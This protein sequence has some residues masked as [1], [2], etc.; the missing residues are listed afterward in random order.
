MSPG[1]QAGKETL[2]ACEYMLFLSRYNQSKF[3]FESHSRPNQSLHNL[4]LLEPDHRIHRL[5]IFEF[6]H[7]GH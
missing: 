6:D 2:K 5:T 7:Q 4:S 1:Q 3:E